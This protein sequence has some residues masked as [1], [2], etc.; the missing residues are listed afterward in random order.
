M[1]NLESKKA[2]VAKYA[3][4]AHD[5]GSAEVQI[6]LWS[7]RI[8]QIA[9]HLIKFP[10]DNHSRHGLVKLVGKRQ[11]AYKYLEKTDKTSFANMKQAMKVTKK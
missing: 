6:A 3:K 9:G 1:L 11:K 10:K 4:S 2:V 5:T 7:E 8:A